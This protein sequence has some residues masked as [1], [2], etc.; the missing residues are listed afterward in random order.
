MSAELTFTLIKIF[1]VVVVAALLLGGFYFFFTTVPE[2]E[3]E[4]IQKTAELKRYHATA[5]VYR[6]RVA[7]FDGV[8]QGLL[9]SD[10]FT[11]HNTDEAY[12][13]ETRLST[14]EYLC[15]DTDGEV[16]M[17]F[18]SKESETACP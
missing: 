3:A 6:G 9:L 5:N 10:D 8:C 18:F 16:G 11:C 15:I 12:A 13:L 17:S 14:G 2:S 1:I 7:S 4:Q